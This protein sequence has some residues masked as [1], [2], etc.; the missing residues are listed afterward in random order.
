MIQGQSFQMY[1]LLGVEDM[2][3]IV[4]TVKLILRARLP[5]YIDPYLH[6]ALRLARSCG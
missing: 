3:G 4:E 2:K 1:R 6:E 5:A